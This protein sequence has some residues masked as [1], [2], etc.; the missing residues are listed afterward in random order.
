VAAVP[1]AGRICE[2]LLAVGVAAAAVV[3]EGGV[4]EAGIEAAGVV[5]AEAEAGSAWDGLA[6]AAAGTYAGEVFV[7]A[8]VAVGIRNGALFAR[9][10]VAAGEGRR[11]VPT[12]FAVRPRTVAS[13]AGAGA[14]AAVAVG[15]GTAGAVVVGRGCGFV[16]A[17]CGNSERC[18]W[19]LVACMR[20]RSL[21]PAANLA[22]RPVGPPCLVPSGGCHFAMTA[23]NPSGAAGCGLAA[24]R[25]HW[26]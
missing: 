15:R 12:S 1:G 4:V 17:C 14:G 18:T 25:R 10:V 3:V 19:P 5:E 9:L 16:I 23:G 8:K 22:A 13:G 2:G 11:Q 20:S 7:R 6:V 24:R 26:R 21:R